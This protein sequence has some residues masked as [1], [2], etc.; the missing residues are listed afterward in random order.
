MNELKNFLILKKEKRQRHH[1][2][3]QNNDM[4]RYQEP[5]Q[6]QNKYHQYI[7]HHEPHP[8]PPQ[9]QPVQ[10]EV[11]LS[12]PA[13]N[14]SIGGY[15]DAPSQLDEGYS[16]ARFNTSII[17]ST[18]AGGEPQQQ[19]NLTDTSRVEE[20]NMVHE[21]ELSSNTLNFSQ[22]TVD[23]SDPDN[24]TRR[25][26]LL[27]TSRMSSG[28]EIDACTGE[29]HYDKLWQHGSSSQGRQ[30]IN[31]EPEYRSYPLNK[32][33]NPEII[34]KRTDRVVDYTQ[35]V[36]M[37]YLQPPT[38]PPAGDIIIRQEADVPCPPAPPLIL[39]EYPKRSVTP[40]PIVL[41]EKP[42]K[43]P[44]PVATRVITIK[45]KEIVPPRQGKKKQNFFSF[46]VI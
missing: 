9:P 35:E 31:D 45:G 17:D 3:T 8:T 26:G 46:I 27:D 15:Y 41:R 25:V 12:Q 4:Y 37:R 7:R 32:D 6:N 10:S 42:P 23:S 38:P 20:N 16:S 44:S 19:Q 29:S 18:A 11:E 2:E 22:F 30:V 28:G 43:P 24:S 5:Q 34:T 40:E 21:T 39:R 33:D 36:T 13:R 14:S 1:E